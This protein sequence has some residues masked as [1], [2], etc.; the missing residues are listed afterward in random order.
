MRRLAQTRD[1]DPQAALTLAQILERTNRLDEA[2]RADRRVCRRILAR[3]AHWAPI[4]A[5][6]RHSSRSATASTSKSSRAVC[7]HRRPNE[8]RCTCGTLSLFALREV[9]GCAEVATTKRSPRR[10]KRISRRSP[11]SELT[12][13]AATARGVPAMTITEY[14]TDPRGCRRSGL[15]P[16]GPSAADSPIFIVAFPRSGTTLMELD[17]GRAPR[18]WSRWTSR[19]SCR[20]R[21]TICSPPASVIRKQL[22]QVSDAQLDHVRARYWERAR[23]KLKIQPGSTAR[24]QESAEP[25]APADDSPRV[26]ERADRPRDPAS[27]RRAAELLSATLPCAGLCAPVQPRR[28]SSAPGYR[29]TFD[30]WYREAAALKPDDS[31]SALR[32][33]RR[34]LRMRRRAHLLEFLDVPWNDAGAGAGRSRTPEGIHQHAELPQVVQPVNQKAVGR[35]KN[36][37]THLQPVLPHVEPYLDRWGYWQIGDLRVKHQIGGHDGLVA[38][39]RRQILRADTSS[40]AGTTSSRP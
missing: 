24:R 39:A 18:A 36:Y 3:C 11:G 8:V 27:V 5:H 28:R 1:L 9:A 30:F 2:R 4:C 12:A 20:R 10:P 31:G 13:A 19:R 35:W 29:K 17:T 37:A 7:R 26:P 14:A 23:T 34:G 15:R 22:G 25:D 38:R 21:S 40:K 32:A 16:R 6:C 33:V